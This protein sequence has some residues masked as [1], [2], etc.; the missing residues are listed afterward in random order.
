MNNS[1]EKDISSQETSSWLEL[2]FWMMLSLALAFVFSGSWLIGIILLL[3]VI[4]FA[5]LLFST[6]P[7]K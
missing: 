5:G 1:N 7:E 6:E 3:S 2:N 4:F